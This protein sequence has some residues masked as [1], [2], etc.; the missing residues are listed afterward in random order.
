MIIFPV[1]NPATFYQL[2]NWDFNSSFPSEENLPSCISD[3]N[4]GKVLYIQ[5]WARGTQLQIQILQDRLDNVNVYAIVEGN[6][7][8]LA[9]VDVTPVNWAGDGNYA[10]VYN[11]TPGIKGYMHFLVE[12]EVLTGKIEKHRSHP[13]DIRDKLKE[14]KK[15]VYH[16]RDNTLNAVFVRDNVRVFAPVIFLEATAVKPLIGGSYSTSKSPYG[17][18]RML[19]GTPSSGKLYEIHNIPLAVVEKIA[20]IFTCEDITINGIYY[21]SEQPPEVNHISGSN[22]STVTV[23]IFKTRWNYVGN[24]LPIYTI[25]PPKCGLEDDI[26]FWF[27][28]TGDLFIDQISGGNYVLQLQ[29]GRLNFVPDD[30]FLINQEF[31]DAVEIFNRNN[32]TIQDSDSADGY[33]AQA[34]Y[35]YS[36]DELSQ[37]AFSD[38]YNDNYMGRVYISSNANEIVAYK[39]DKILDCDAAALEYVEQDEFVTDPIGGENI[40]IF[41]KYNLIHI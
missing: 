34:P 41:N 19:R 17:V 14:C 38:F 2:R 21:Q 10:V 37:K 18:I 31:R 15:V 33:S 29:N 40:L 35:S 7:V 36:L 9:G 8:P 13:L 20:T 39:T 32:T 23:E 26:Q 1:I 25:E 22:A 28:R 4:V 16:K 3:Y 6:R 5:P 12:E 27:K 30:Q 11:Y 24:Y